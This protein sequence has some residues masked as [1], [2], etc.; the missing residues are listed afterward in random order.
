MFQ[1]L[2]K[3]PFKLWLKDYAYFKKIIKALAQDSMKSFPIKNAL[4]I[5]FFKAYFKK[6]L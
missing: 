5:T 3:K 6:L 1:R 4:L 2:F